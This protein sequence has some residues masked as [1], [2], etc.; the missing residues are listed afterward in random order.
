[1]KKFEKYNNWLLALA[2]VIIVIVVY[3]T[4]DNFY[5]IVEIGGIILKSLSPFLIGFVIAYILNMPCKKIDNL[6]RKSKNRFINKKSKAIGIISVYLM[7]LL[8]I[9]VVVSAVAPALYRNILDLYNNIP[10]YVD[11]LMAAIEGWQKTYNIDI[12]N[13]N[14]ANLTHAFNAI[15]GKFDVTELS[16]YAKGVIDITSGVISIFIGIII[17]VYMLIDK[18]KIKASCRR[19]LY[20]ILKEE[21]SSKLIMYVKRI[22]GVFSKY[23]FCLLLDALI[24]AVAATTVLSILNVK[25]A[26]ILGLMIGVLNL[27]PY[28][29]AICAAVLSIIIT[30]ITGGFFQALW[31]AIA[32]IVLQQ[33]DGNFIGPKIMGQVLDAS[34][35]WIIFAVT[36]GGG[37]FGILGMI[38][39]VPVLVTIKMAVSEFIDEKETKQSED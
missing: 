17:S 18:E 5:K 10:A 11:K 35:L 2:F 36:L 26:M 27:I 25:Y 24:M 23:I 33:I 13:I 20:L 19:V 39:S 14:E 30:L 38:I 28:F 29:G 12:F 6:C 22:N 8:V 3:K 21:K 16:K 15:L 32:L 9:Y 4:F 37:L 7:M 34:P 1:M 31:T